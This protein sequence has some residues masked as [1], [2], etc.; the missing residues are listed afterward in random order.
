MYLFRKL[1]VLI[2]QDALTLA[3]DELAPAPGHHAPEQQHMAEVIHIVVERERVRKVHADAAVY[4]GGALVAVVHQRLHGLELLRRGESTVKLDAR[5]GGELYD[6][7]LREVFHAAADVERPFIPHRAGVCVH[8]DE[9]KLIEPA[10]DVPLFI[11]IAAGLTRTHSD[12]ED[13]RIL[14]ADR[15]GERGDVPVVEDAEGYVAEGI[16]NGTDVDVLDLRVEKLLRDF[17][18]ERGVHGAVVYVHAGA[19]HT[20]RVHARHVC[21]RRLERGDDAVIVVIRVGVRLGKP[22]DLLGIH[23]L[24]VDDGG[25]LAVAAA[26]IKAYAAAVKVPARGRGRILRLG[27]NVGINYLKGAFIYLGEIVPVKL[28]AAAGAE[29][30]ADVLIH[31]AIAADIHAPA[32]LHPEQRLDKAAD[33]IPVGVKHIGSAVDERVNGGHLAAAALH[34]DAEGLL[35]RG[36]KGVVELIEREKITVKLRKVPDA[37]LNAE[38]VHALRPPFIQKFLRCYLDIVYYITPWSGCHQENK[39]IFQTKILLKIIFFNATI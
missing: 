27:Q 2:A 19:R 3:D 35:C 22:H 18:K 7:V 13:V 24:T 10:G 34:G 36:E 25:D 37:C 8:G 1:A 32:A 4:R 39:K 29:A 15:P 17:K 20:D 5:R 12:A 14:K 11:D 26:R 28:L 38:I 30:A 33:V 21:R 9:S 16:G 31:I 6:A 23:G